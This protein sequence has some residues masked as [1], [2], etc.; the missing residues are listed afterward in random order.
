[1]MVGCADIAHARCNRGAATVKAA[2][3]PQLEHPK[4]VCPEEKGFSVATTHERPCAL[5]VISFK[6]KY[7]HR[8]PGFVLSFQNAAEYPSLNGS[9]RCAFVLPE[10]SMQEVKCRKQIPKSRSSTMMSRCARQ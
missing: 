4:I 1:M 3:I 10:T 5:A 8:T 7:N 6:P 9:E 2:A